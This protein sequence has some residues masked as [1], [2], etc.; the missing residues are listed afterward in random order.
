MMCV[1]GIFKMTDIT[2]CQT[3]TCPLRATCYRHNTSP[4]MYQSYFIEAPYN[5]IEG[6][7]EYYW[8]GN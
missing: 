4:G 5:E 2:M 8:E 7:C 1:G 6:I 3:D